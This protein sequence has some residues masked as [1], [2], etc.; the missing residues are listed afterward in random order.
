MIKMTDKSGETGK[1]M[2]CYR[3]VKCAAALENSLVVPQKDKHGVN[4]SSN[5]FTFRYISK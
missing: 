1:L 4:R 5:Y 2:H 3:D